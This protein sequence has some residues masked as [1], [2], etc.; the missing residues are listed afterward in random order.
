MRKKNFKNHYFQLFDPSSNAWIL[1]NSELFQMERADDMKKLILEGKFILS[2]YSTRILHFKPEYECV[3]ALRTFK[4]ITIEDL[5]MFFEDNHR[6]LTKRRK[7]I[8]LKLILRH[9]FE[10]S[11]FDKNRFMLES[12]D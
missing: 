9:I 7:R 3:F 12:Y 1:L 4:Q 11:S 2:F 10:E 5:T 8:G 6:N